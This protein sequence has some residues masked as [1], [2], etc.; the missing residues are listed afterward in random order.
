MTAMNERQREAK[1]KDKEE[2]NQKRIEYR[3]YMQWK[4]CGIVHDLEQ[5]FQ[6]TNP[7]LSLLLPIALSMSKLIDVPIGRQEKRHKDLLIGWLNKNYAAI[8]KY[9]PRMVIRDEKGNING[10]NADTWKR[11]TEEHP[12]TDV[13]SSL[14]KS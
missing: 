8:Q 3:E 7:T 13:L 12:G 5:Q 1:G 4:G 11:F 14:S 10:P 9:I 2:I 6:V